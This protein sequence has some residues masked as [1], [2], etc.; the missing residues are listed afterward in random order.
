[1]R[2]VTA[3]RT[4]AAAL[5]ASANALEAIADEAEREGAASPACSYCTGKSGT[6]PPGKSRRWLRDHA[7][8]IPGA[9]KLGRD[10]MVTRVDFDRWVDAQQTAKP[11]RPPFASPSIAPIINIDELLERNGLRPTGSGTR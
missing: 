7:P 8:A 11:L 6:L 3:L 2:S 5:R 9:R 4:Q 10:W 1:M